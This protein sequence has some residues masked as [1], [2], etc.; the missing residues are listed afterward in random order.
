MLLTLLLLFLVGCGQQDEWER[1]VKAAELLNDITEDSQLREDT[2]E[3]LDALITDD[4]TGAYGTMYAGVDYN[5]FLKV[6]E[7]LSLGLSNIEGYQLVAS[8]I[9]KSVTNGQATVSVRYMMT[10]GKQRFFVDVARADGYDGLIAFYVN[11]YV[12]VTTTGTLGNMQDANVLQWIILMVGLLEVVFVVWVFVDCCRHKMR[13]KWL[14]L[15]IIALGYL[16]VQLIATPEQFRLGM[17]LGAFLSY[18]S[19]VC[20]STGGFTLRLMIPA[21]AVIYL[22]LRKRLFANYVQFQQQKALAAQEAETVEEIRVLTA[23]SEELVQNEEL[24]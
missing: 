2:E 10:A 3:M 1:A 5:E 14:W 6:Y 13:K 7:Q 20:Y 16:V 22:I 15:L 11:E 23:E 9:N 8:N 19:L 12:P 17:R 21:G 18:T 24:Q 4:V